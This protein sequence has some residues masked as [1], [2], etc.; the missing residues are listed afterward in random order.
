MTTET[1]TQPTDMVAGCD[2]C[3]GDGIYYG[4]GHVENGV[5]R[6]FKGTCY[7]CGGKGYQTAKDVRRNTYYDRRVRRV[8]A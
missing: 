6:G 1:Q 8:F 4:R 7:R 2:G 3:P 5:F